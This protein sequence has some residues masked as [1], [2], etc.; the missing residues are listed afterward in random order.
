M[1]VSTKIINQNPTA[2]VIPANFEVAYA[3]LEALVAGMESGDM[4]LDDALKAYQRGHTLLQFCQQA[5]GEVEQSV[6]LLNAKNSLDQFM[7]VNE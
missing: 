3:E 7:P 1:T 6:Q 5:L 4:I 2:E